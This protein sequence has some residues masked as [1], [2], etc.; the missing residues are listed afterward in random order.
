[1]SYHVETTLCHDITTYKISWQHYGSTSLLIY[2]QPCLST[3]LGLHNMT[4]MTQL[5]FS[6]HSLPCTKNILMTP[7]PFPPSL[8]TSCATFPT[9]TSPYSSNPPP[10]LIIYLTMADDVSHFLMMSHNVLW[11]LIVSHDVSQCLIN[12]MVCHDVSS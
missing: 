9:V 3:I 11:C 4:T 5:L 2:T 1:M 12:V 7:Q 6:H 10:S 8:V